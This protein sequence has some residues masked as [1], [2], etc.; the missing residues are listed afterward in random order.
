MHLF[1]DD[2]EGWSDVLIGGKGGARIDRDRLRITMEEA[3]SGFE[4]GRSRFSRDHDGEPA[5]RVLLERCEEQGT[6]LD[7]CP[8]DLYTLR[9]AGDARE[10]TALRGFGA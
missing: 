9:S 8:R 1:A 4:V 5:L 7:R 6:R 2:A 3:K 10:D